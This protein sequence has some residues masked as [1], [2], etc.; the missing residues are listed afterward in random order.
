MLLNMLDTAAVNVKVSG[1]HHI[2][3]HLLQSFCRTDIKDMK[4]K[5]KKK[6]SQK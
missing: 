2:L 4:V 3:F 1:G 6:K 5:K